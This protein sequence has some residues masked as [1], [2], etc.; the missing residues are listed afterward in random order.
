MRLK[1]FYNGS[2]EGCNIY[3]KGELCSYEDVEVAIL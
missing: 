3:V 1:L 2:Y